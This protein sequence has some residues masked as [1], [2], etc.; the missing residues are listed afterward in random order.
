MTYESEYT[1]LTIDICTP[2]K[3]HESFLMQVI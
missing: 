3:D 1:D 2:A